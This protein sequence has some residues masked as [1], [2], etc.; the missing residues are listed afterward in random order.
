MHHVLLAEEEHCARELEPINILLDATG[1]IKDFR[2]GTRF[3]ARQNLAL[4][5]F[6]PQKS[7]STKNTVALS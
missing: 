6:V 2:L 4:F 5:H 1:N 7:F 3:M